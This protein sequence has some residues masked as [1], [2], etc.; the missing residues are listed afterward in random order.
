MEEGLERDDLF[1]TLFE[2]AAECAAAEREA[3]VRNACARDAALAEELLE[4][5]AWQDRMG[6]FLTQPLIGR[7]PVDE[8][9]PA[10]ELVCDRSAS[11]DRSPKAEWRWSTRRSTR[12]STSA[13]P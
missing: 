3:Y 13:E 2:A 8:P 11:C 1:M 5:L 10:G 7:A 12:N 6:D 4:R 9:F